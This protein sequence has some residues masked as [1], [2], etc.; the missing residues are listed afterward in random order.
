MKS[1]LLIASFMN[2]KPSLLR[3]LMSI[4][5]AAK[6]TEVAAVFSLFLYPKVHPIIPVMGCLLKMHMY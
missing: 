4:V 1:C 2:Q 6:V 5:G 3:L